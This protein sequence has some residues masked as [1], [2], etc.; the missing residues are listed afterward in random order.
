MRAHWEHK[1]TKNS[2]AP[3]SPPPPKKL[4]REKKKPAETSPWLDKF[5]IS[6]TIS[7][8]FQ[9]VLI[10]PPIINWGCLLTRNS[11]TTQNHEL[12][13]CAPYCDTMVVVHI[14]KGVGTRVLKYHLLKNISQ[15][16]VGTYCLNMAA[17]EYF[18]LKSGVFGLF[19]FS[20][21]SLY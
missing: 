19:S 11:S 17:R 1:K 20:Q 2:P 9:P 15:R 13:I 12:N 16:H 6:K 18:P 5:S 4:K 7:H 21:K 14:R 10:I 8:H 3:S